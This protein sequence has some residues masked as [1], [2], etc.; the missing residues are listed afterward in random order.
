[1]AAFVVERAVK[2]TPHLTLHQFDFQGLP[3]VSNPDQ[4]L[5]LWHTAEIVVSI[6][7]STY[8]ALIVEIESEARFSIVCLTYLLCVYCG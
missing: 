8:N 5:Y 7:Q 6:S 1:M 3:S 4:M 2:L